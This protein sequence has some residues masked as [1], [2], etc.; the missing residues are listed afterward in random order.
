MKNS[1]F[2]HNPYDEILRQNDVDQIDNHIKDKFKKVP[3]RVKN[4]AK[5][6]ATGDLKIIIQII[7]GFIGMIGLSALVALVLGIDFNL[8]AIIQNPSSK[9]ILTILALIIVSGFIFYKT[10]PL[11]AQSI[12]DYKRDKKMNGYCD[13]DDKRMGFGLSAVNIVFS[14]IGAYVLTATVLNTR[15]TNAMQ[16]VINEYQPQIEKIEA[17]KTATIGQL[18]GELAE[19][20]SDKY[21]NRKGEI[22]HRQYKNINKARAGLSSAREQYNT[23]LTG[24]R[25]RFEAAKEEVKQKHGL[26][27]ANATTNTEQNILIIAGMGSFQVF[28]EICLFLIIGFRINYEFKSMIEIEAEKTAIKSN[29]THQGQYEPQPT[30]TPTP[31]TQMSPIDLTKDTNYS[32]TDLQ[33]KP[34]QRNQTPPYMG[35]IKVPT[36]HGETSLPPSVIKQRIKTSIRTEQNKEAFDLLMKAYENHINQIAV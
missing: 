6:E 13:K 26:D 34:E 10:E 28:L 20:T 31:Q 18:E 36:K 19:A 22:Y 32:S 30:P 27:A 35:Q 2:G 24:L 9:N 16:S 29:F 8:N 11:K 15:G 4:R 14:L 5:Y 7:S 25:E 23:T 21:K 12:A 1:N 3:K 33:I 17:E